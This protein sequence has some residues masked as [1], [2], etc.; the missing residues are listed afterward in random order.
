MFN[1][2]NFKQVETQFG[3]LYL[4]VVEDNTD[5]DGAG[6]VQVRIVGIHTPK[7]EKSNT[8]GIPTSE[9]PWAIPMNPVGGGAVSGLGM[10]SVPVQGSYVVIFFIGGNHNYPIYMGCISG[11]PQNSADSSVGFNDPDGKYP[12][13]TEE[14]DWN[15]EAR[16]DGNEVIKDLKNDNLDTL[17]PTSTAS[18][19]YP[20]NHVFE[21]PDGGIIVEYDS[22]DGNERYH[23][24]HK[25]SKSY[26]EMLAN[27]DMIMKSTN[28][29]FEITSNDRKVFVKNNDTQQIDGTLEITVGGKATIKGTIVDIDGGAG[30]PAGVITRACKCAFTGQDHPD[31]SS[32]VN[33]SK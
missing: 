16:A 7:K 6:K 20:N 5:P 11:L 28:N 32:D 12:L 22:T 33:S 8:E 18:P 1:H 21:T 17:E 27:G 23:V 9:L 15:R 14:P 3:G 24:F 2:E 26:M 25:A 31:F 13:H 19:V 4:G 10:N 30:S 29:K